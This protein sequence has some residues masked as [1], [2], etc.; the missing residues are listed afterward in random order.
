MNAPVK[1][2]LFHKSKNALQISRDPAAF[3]KKQLQLPQDYFYLSMPGLNRVW[4]AT[5]PEGAKAVL[6]APDTVLTSSLPSPLEP[7]LGQHSLILLQSDN[8]TRE[9]K[10]L[11]PAFQGTCLRSYE[12]LMRHSIQQSLARLPVQQ[13][14]NIQELLQEVTLNVII[15]VVFGINGHERMQHY[16]AAIRRVL[17][18]FTPA[19]MLMPA[20]RKSC[21]GISPWD[22]FVKARD[23]LDQLL[24]ADIEKAREDP[25]HGNSVLSILV[26]KPEDNTEPLTTRQ[27]RD[28]LI[29]LLAAGHETT[30]N[31][32]TWLIFCLGD[33]SDV[34]QRLRD[35]ILS[36]PADTSLERLMKLPYLDAV[37]KEVLRCYPVVPLVMR[38][39]IAPFSA[40]GQTQSQSTY[41]GI[42]TY[43]LHYHPA[44]WGDPDQFRPERFLEQEFTAF[45]YLPFGGGNKKCLGYGFALF[46]MKLILFHLFQQMEVEITNDM[47]VKPAIQG[48]TLGPRQAVLATLTRYR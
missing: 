19:I 2:S 27:I 46:E 14:V 23:Q 5:G 36:Q 22:R 40:L 28:E 25:A 16:Q 32:L 47:P 31:S 7:L 1:S 20:A 17:H 37:I 13:L 42:A 45:E 48:I 41:A 34:H 43:S 38:S 39:V 18:Y 35:E 30:A 9:R 21:L 3:F 6:Q 12:S 33:N 44:V 4:M 11:K 26:R 10:R 8:H 24:L 29:T 15:Q